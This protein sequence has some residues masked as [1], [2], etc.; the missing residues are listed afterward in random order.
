MTGQKYEQA[1]AQ[2]Q[3]ETCIANLK[4]IS[5]IKMEGDSEPAAGELSEAEKACAGWENL[6]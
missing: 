4:K 1:D 6:P 5:G 2:T 3:L